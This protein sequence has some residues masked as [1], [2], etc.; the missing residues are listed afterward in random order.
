MRDLSEDWITLRETFHRAREVSHGV[1]AKGLAALQRALRANEIRCVARGITI[2]E[3]H[4]CWVF[5]ETRSPLHHKGRP[6]KWTEF[7]AGH[8]LTITMEKEAWSAAYEADNRHDPTIYKFHIEGAIFV[9]TGMEKIADYST[10]RHTVPMR[11][12]VSLEISDD[13]RDIS[14][15]TINDGPN[16][17]RLHSR[18]WRNSVA[19]RVSAMDVLCLRSDVDVAFPYSLSHPTRAERGRPSAQGRIYAFLEKTYGGTDVLPS[20]AE[21]KDELLD[22][23]AGESLSFSDSTCYKHIKIW[24]AGR[25]SV[26]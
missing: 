6:L 21:I 8:E 18:Y 9:F 25:H 11:Q 3:S 24:R 7:P 4:H 13:K 23:L 12:I 1:Q 5:S 10:G 14:L 2:W 17:Q 15:E 22:H 16:E 19:Q 20:N 26:K